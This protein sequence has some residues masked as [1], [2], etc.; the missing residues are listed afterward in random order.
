MQEL[1]HNLEQSELSDFNEWSDL[2]NESSN[3]LLF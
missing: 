1:Q 2:S 3:I